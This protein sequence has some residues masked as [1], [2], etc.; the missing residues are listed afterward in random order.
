ME[1]TP[2]EILKVANLSR[3]E[4][5]EKE[6]DVIADQIGNILNYITKLNELDTEGVKVTT[7]ATS[8]HNAFREDKVV[9]S[10]SQ[11]NVLQNAPRQNGESFVV[12]KVL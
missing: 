5:D 9:E 2:E 12:P 7:H 4:I 8:S 10:L 6:V 3:L 11:E 1:I